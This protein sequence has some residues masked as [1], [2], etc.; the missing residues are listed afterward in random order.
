MGRNP[1]LTAMGHPTRASILMAMNS[2]KRRLSPS[3]FS[4]ETGLDVRH[5][6]YHFTQLAKA[7][8]I[9]LVET[10]Q[11]LRGSTEHIYEPSDTALAWTSEWEELSPTIKRAV[12]SS[13]CKAAVETLGSAIDGGTFES[14]DESHLSWNTIEVDE[15]GW[16]E[17]A[18]ILDRALTDFMKIEKDCAVRLGEGDEYFIASY[19][20][21]GFESPRRFE[22]MAAPIHESASRQA[23]TPTKDKSRV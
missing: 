8:C 17:M 21:F 4:D 13:V 20:M 15:R 12:L 6:S 19:F 18:E 23:L 2:P 7:R 10:R 5:C 1:V 11:G 16:T 9:S 22:S 3:R 14:R